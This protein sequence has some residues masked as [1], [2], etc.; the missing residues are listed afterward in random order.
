MSAPNGASEAPSV[1]VS[2]ADF[3]RRKFRQQAEEQKSST[4]PP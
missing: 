1:Y 3:L 4:T 2:H